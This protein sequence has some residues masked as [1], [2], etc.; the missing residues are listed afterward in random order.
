[1]NIIERDLRVERDLYVSVKYFRV[2]PFPSAKEYGLVTWVTS[3][4]S[5]P[6]DY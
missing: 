3:L 1:M 6:E 2:P 4:D 5:R